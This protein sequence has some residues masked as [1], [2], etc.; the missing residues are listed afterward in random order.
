MVTLTPNQMI[1]HQEFDPWK[2]RLVGILEDD[3]D[4]VYYVNF[5]LDKDSFLVARIKHR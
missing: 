5:E 3:K 4:V 1:S 2:K